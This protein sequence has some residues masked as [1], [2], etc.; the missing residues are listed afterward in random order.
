MKAYR[1]SLL[2][3][4]PHSEGPAHA[5]FE[6]DGMLVVGPNAAGVQVVQAIGSYRDLRER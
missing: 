2:W 4:A 3:F 1:A 6:E 5:L